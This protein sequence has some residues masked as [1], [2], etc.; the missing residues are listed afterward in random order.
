MY[1]LVQKPTTTRHPVSL[2]SKLS[3]QAP[4][5]CRRAVHPIPYFEPSPVIKQYIDC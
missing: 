1:T 5:M 4:L 2:G 3:A